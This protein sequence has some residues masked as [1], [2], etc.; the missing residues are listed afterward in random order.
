MAFGLRKNYAIFNFKSN[1]N[2]K[3]NYY[4][5]PYESRFATKYFSLKAKNKIYE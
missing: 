3:V 2:P 1:L 4:F 5:C